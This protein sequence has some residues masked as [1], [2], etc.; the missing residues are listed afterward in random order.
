MQPD[1]IFSESPI[2]RQDILAKV[3][4][5]P[6]RHII[7]HVPILDTIKTEIFMPVAFDLAYRLDKI[8]ELAVIRAEI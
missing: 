5:L 2:G 4:L 1:Q 3:D 6:L 7:L 8:L